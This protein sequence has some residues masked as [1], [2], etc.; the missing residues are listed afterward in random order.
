MLSTLAASALGLNIG[1]T[2]APSSSRGAVSMDLGRPLR[3]AVVGG[4]PSGACAAE[5][6]AKAS[7]APPRPAP[8]RPPLA[9]AADAAAFLA[10]RRRAPRSCA[11][12]SC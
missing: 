6:F 10:Q 11:T 7:V 4:G 1:A 2:P 5:I 3:V 8:R 12:R 9:D